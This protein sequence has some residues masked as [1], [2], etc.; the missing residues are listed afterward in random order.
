[1]IQKLSF[2][3]FDIKEMHMDK[4]GSI[5]DYLPQYGSTMQLFMK[6]KITGY[7]QWLHT[8]VIRSSDTHSYQVR[9][10]SMTQ[11]IETEKKL[12]QSLSGESNNDDE[13]KSR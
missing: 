11:L 12:F 3:Q 10:D 6:Y 1:M 4:S 8:F 9:S 2:V 7:Y 5:S 13:S